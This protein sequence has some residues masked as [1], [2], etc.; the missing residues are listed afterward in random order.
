MLIFIL[1]NRRQ[2]H[3]RQWHLVSWRNN[4]FT[5]SDRLRLQ[6]AY[7]WSRFTGNHKNCRKFNL[8]LNCDTLVV[9]NRS[10]LIKIVIELNRIFEVLFSSYTS[11]YL[12]NTDNLCRWYKEK[13]IRNSDIGSKINVKHFLNLYLLNQSNCIVYNL[14]K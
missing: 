10:A 14:Q 11:D 3:T 9:I 2:S 7:Q 12:Q 5:T 6:L 8:N 4:S 13:T 1:S